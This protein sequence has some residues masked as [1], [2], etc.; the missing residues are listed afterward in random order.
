MTVLKKTKGSSTLSD[1]RRKLGFSLT[2]LLVVIA[3]LATLSSLL[4]PSVRKGLGIARSSQCLSQL[5]KLSLGMA[6]YMNDYNEIFP[7]AKSGNI[8]WIMRLMGGTYDGKVLDTSVVEAQAPGPVYVGPELFPC[9]EDERVQS[10]G[11][12]NLTLPTSVNASY[13]INSYKFIPKDATIGGIS[14]YVDWTNARVNSI[15]SSII[16]IYTPSSTLVLAENYGAW[17][18]NGNR[19]YQ[20]NR[21]RDGAI[22][23]SIKD[24]DQF[25]S[26]EVRQPIHDGGMGAAYLMVDGHAAILFPLDTMGTNGTEE[27]PKGMWSKDPKD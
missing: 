11:L 3:V 18:Y 2:E 14:G 22:E 25:D 20:V 4:V 24:A 19:N 15:T 23:G 12:L 27:D 5:N 17:L 1:G 10:Y 6:I 16:D 8:N 13:A 26:K 7:Y 9:P 21:I